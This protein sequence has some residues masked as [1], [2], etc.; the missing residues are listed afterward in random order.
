MSKKKMAFSPSLLEKNTLPKNDRKKAATKYL[1][2]LS[3]L[4]PVFLSSFFVVVVFT[5]DTK[6]SNTSFSLPSFC[7]ET[8]P[9]KRKRHDL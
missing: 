9:I 4:K 7:Q 3:L 8:H 6:K 5:L 1:Y 2:N